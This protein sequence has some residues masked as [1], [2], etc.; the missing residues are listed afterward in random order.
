MGVA[1][2]VVIGVG[3]LATMGLITAD[4]TTIAS[5][6]SG[7]P[8]TDPGQVLEWTGTTWRCDE[9]ENPS[10]V[11]TLKDEFWSGATNCTTVGQFFTGAVTGTSACGFNNAD[12]LHPG[13]VSLTT[14]AVAT[15]GIRFASQTNSIVFG[16]VPRC[17]TWLWKIHNLSTS[18][19]Q[20]VDRVGYAEPATNADSVDAVEAV[21]DFATSGVNKWALITSAN[22]V[23]TTTACTGATGDI[24]A[25]TWYKLKVCVNAAATSATLTIND[26]L[27]A[28]AST[29]IP[30][31]TSRGTAIGAQHFNASGS[32]PAAQLSFADF[33]KEVAPFP[34]AR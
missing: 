12:L 15:D 1:M 8:C 19:D 32:V 2:G 27:C 24:A 4:V 33:V 3:L 29:N 14:D 20:Y 13:S 30:S 18:V 21:Y 23:R 17:V 25:D 34:V 22:S 26:V 16:S 10:L 7:T 31:G 28:T 11:V 9:S 5:L 6:N